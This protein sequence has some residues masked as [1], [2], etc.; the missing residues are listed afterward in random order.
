MTGLGLFDRQDPGDTGELDLDE[1]R[2]ALAA[3]PAPPPPLSRREQRIEHA[4]R[5]RAARER[6]RSRRRSTW[7]AVL[8][9]VLLAA[10]LAAGLMAWRATHDDVADHPG[11]G[12]TEVIVRIQRG[13]ALD[14]IAATLAAAGV[15]ASPEAFARHGVGDAEVLALT[16]GYYKVRQG[17]SAAAAADDLVAKE[18]R[19]GRLRVIP[20]RQLADV[21]N[22]VS[23]AAEAGTVTPGYITAITEAACQPLNGRQDCFTAEQLWAVA[24][25][26]DP[27]ELGVVDWAVD[28]VNAA[29]DPRKRLEGL[30][31]PGDYDVPPG[32][33]PEAAL[34]AV[35]SASAA[36]WSQT[37]I[38]TGS[39]SVGVSPYQAAIIASLVEREGVAGDMPRVARVI[40]N[41]L[42]VPMKLQ[43]DSTVNY[44]LD[45]AQIATS[46]ADRA[47]PN[48]YNTYAVDGLPPTPIS[49]PG[50]AALEA[51]EQ[52]ASGQWMY[53]VKLDASGASCF[54]DTAEQHQVCV[55]QARANG[56]FG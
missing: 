56:V 41:R 42:A 15:V 16:P 34:R 43:F 12:E 5:R 47:N 21:S 36:L 18:N 52:P 35:V 24:E 6:R 33:S 55:D 40:Y 32:P 19:V 11:V 31:L 50:G 23:G 1:L 4:E 53:F 51:T 9:L 2:A 3:N 25:S 10:G 30:I 54:S 17:S 38:I 45:R 48:P 26:A 28:G 13:D 27:V 49:S 8:V 44:A 20:G 14:D 39:R 46:D 7:I 29:P 37:G 22:T